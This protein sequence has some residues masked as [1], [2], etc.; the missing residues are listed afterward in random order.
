MPAMA[1]INTMAS[2]N[3]NDPRRTISGNQ[4]A[5]IKPHTINSLAIEQRRTGCVSYRVAWMP[6]GGGITSPTVHGHPVDQAT[7]SPSQTRK[8]H[9][10]A[11]P[12]NQA[13]AVSPT[14][15][16]N[17]INSASTVHSFRLR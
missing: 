11:F 10:H 8:R 15:N 3:G 6:R 7:G 13:H 9:H 2:Q 1:T 16:N 5:S 17:K 4:L 14:A 12:Q